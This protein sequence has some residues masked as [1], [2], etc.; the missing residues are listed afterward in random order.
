MAQ[1]HFNGKTYNDIAEMPATERQAYEQMMDMFMD[2][3]GNGIPDFLEGDMVKNVMSVYSSQM[4]V[5]GKA[6]NSLDD[7]PPELRASVDS[8]FK[9]LANMGILPGMPAQSQVQN[10]FENP[11]EAL[12]SKPFIS[13]EYNPV[14]QED[15]GPSIAT[16]LFVGI[17]LILCL[18]IAAVAVFF[19]I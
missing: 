3:N 5:N 4:D 14:I 18:G 15:K 11:P 9:M 8:A 13:R 16:W 7:L 19:I 2:K 17:G 10:Q 6:Y 1:I 12:T